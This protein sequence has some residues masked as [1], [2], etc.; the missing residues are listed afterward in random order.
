MHKNYTIKQPFTH[1]M[2]FDRDILP[3]NQ[4]DRLV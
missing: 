1:H 4:Q 2:T 3:T